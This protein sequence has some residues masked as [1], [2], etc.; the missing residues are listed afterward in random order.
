MLNSLASKIRGLHE[1]AT[2]LAK[3]NLA[4]SNECLFLFLYPIRVV[5]LTA[6]SD[7]LFLFFS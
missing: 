3:E 4:V 1:H 5:L 2:K 7:L 6:V